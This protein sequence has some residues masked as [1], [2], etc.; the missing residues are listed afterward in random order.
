MEKKAIIIKAIEYMKDHLDE[1]ITTE[2]LS[3]YVGYSPY[4]FVR[5]FKE[6]TG[7]SPRHYLSALR[8]EA[9]KKILADSSSSIL[10]ASLSVGYRSMGTFSSLFKQYV[11]LPPKQYQ[12]SIQDL[13]GFLNAYDFQET[14]RAFQPPLPSVVCHLEPPEKFN[15]IIFV[16]LFPRPIPDERPV[17]GTALK[18]GETTCA[19]YHVPDGTYYAL[20]AAISWSLNP[21]DYFL[22]NRA[23]RGKAERPVAVKQGSQ[24]VVRIKLREPLPYDP[25]ILINLPRLLFEKV[26]GANKKKND[27]DFF[28]KLKENNT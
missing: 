12:N 8:I 18:P 3:K 20:A 17:A 15:G 5:I 6:V 7:V 11:G 13:Y 24:S 19:F 23:L 16:G 28:D 1:E 2:E 25:P 14:D 4:H 26:K 21:K 22:L 10:K 9:G 27:S